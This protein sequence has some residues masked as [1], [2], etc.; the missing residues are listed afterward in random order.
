MYVFGANFFSGFGVKYFSVLDSP[1][2]FVEGDW[3]VVGSVVDGCGFVG[4]GGVC[5][6]AA[7]EVCG[8]DG[9][10][11]VA[12]VVLGVVDCCLEGEFFGEYVVP[13]FGGDFSVVDSSVESFAVAE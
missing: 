4:G 11:V 8:H 5:A 3:F 7:Y 9:C 13:G 12:V 6:V 2:P 1:I 10:G